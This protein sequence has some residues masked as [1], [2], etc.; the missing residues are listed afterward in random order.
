MVMRR[1]AFGCDGFDST[2]WM[3][4]KEEA[5]WDLICH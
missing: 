4:K 1:H 3:V 5:K 2:R